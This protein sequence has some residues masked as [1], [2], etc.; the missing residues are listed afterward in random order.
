MVRSAIKQLIKMLVATRSN[1]ERE[2]RLVQEAGEG[3]GVLGSG[4]SR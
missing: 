3:A 4:S 1:K 2:P